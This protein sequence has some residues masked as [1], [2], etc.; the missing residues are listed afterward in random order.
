VSVKE[1]VKRALPERS[2]LFVRRFGRL[3]WIT[4]ARKLRAAGAGQWRGRPLRIARYVVL[5]PEIDTYSYEIENVDELAQRLAV[6][7]ERPGEELRGLLEEAM[8]NPEL[9][10][11]L[12]EDI[13]WRVLFFKRR[14]PIAGHHLA[15][16]ALVRA[17]RPA[18]AIETGIL[19]GL[20]SRTIL[21]ALERNAAEGDEGH[22]WSFDV[23][24][25]AGALVPAR[26]ASRWTAVYR[27]AEEAMPGVLAGRR[28]DFFLH[29][30]LPD[31]QH[32]RFELET[33]CAHARPGAILMTTHG[34]TG[35]L[36]GLSAT[37]AMACADFHERP[38]DHFYGGR[39]LAWARLR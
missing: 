17:L 35:V 14:P 1:Q 23:M 36:E 29:D 27:P 13:G 37:R 38:R 11:R 24:P 18:V 8:R 2:R 25:G 10:E 34:W 15:A 39:Q 4:K 28:L 30:S 33:A 31:P 22:L 26:L 3:R 19:D 16:Y 7:T 9:H 21:A 20:G 32:Q 6:V 5:D 12:T